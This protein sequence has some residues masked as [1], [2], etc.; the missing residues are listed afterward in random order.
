MVTGLEISSDSGIGPALDRYNSATPGITEAYQDLLERR[1]WQLFR[2]A[3]IP[4][5]RADGTTPGAAR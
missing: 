3:T 4:A 5:A 1:R 2:D